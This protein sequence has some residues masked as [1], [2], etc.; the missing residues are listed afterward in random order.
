MLG[1]PGVEGLEQTKADLDR[2]FRDALAKETDGLPYAIYLDANLPVAASGDEELRWM[3]DVQRMLDRRDAS[4]ESHDPFVGVTVNNFSWHYAGDAPTIGRGESVLVV[5]RYPR[6]P[7]R[8]P[9]TLRLIFEAARQ[10]G[11]VPG[12]FPET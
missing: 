7:L 8:D 10:Y 2:L 5:P 11:D 1:R 4:P 12:L 9:R 3:H 6:V